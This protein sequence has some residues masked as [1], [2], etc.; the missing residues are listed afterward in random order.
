ML[1]RP[2]WLAG[3]ALVVLMAGIFI[4]LGLWQYGRH[5]DERDA[6]A[7]T[8]A[9][10]A[11]PAPTLGELGA[12]AAEGVRVELVGTYEADA[13]VLWRNRV[14]GGTSG[15]DVLTPL[16][17]ADGTSVLVDRGWI[18]RTTAANGLATVA[19]PEGP[20]T[21]RGVLN[22]TRPLR[23]DDAV[24][25]RD[26]NATVPRVDVEQVATAIAMPL[27]DLWVTAQYQSPPPAD[28][29]PELPEPPDESSVSHLSY[30]YQ[31]F[32]LALIPLIGW[33]IVLYRI[34]RR[35]SP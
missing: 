1:L 6:R 8:E 22:E 24:E 4:A 13:E 29:G 20:V 33:P 2:R 17:L 23:P 21:V 11:A 18:A 16:V 14:R 25:E 30:T 35:R 12:D 26:G 3:H 7:A 27:H 15:F 28:A 31:W 10:F 32:A 19:P 34:T 5:Q 9:E